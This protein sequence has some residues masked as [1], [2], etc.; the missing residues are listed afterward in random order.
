VERD[1]RGTTVWDEVERFVR[2]AMEP[3]FGRITELSGPRVSPDGRQVACTGK[4]WDRLEGMARSRICLVD[5]DGD[6]EIRQI[7]NGPNDDA[8]PVWSPDGTRLIFRSD[9]ASAGRYQLYVLETG[10]LGEARQLAEI[11][12]VVEHHAWSPDGSRILVVVAGANAE[13]ADALGSGTLTEQD[14]AASWLPDVESSDDPDEARRL[15]IVDPSSG[16]VRIVGRNDLNVWE[17]SWCGDAAI[18]A[19]AGPGTEEGAWYRSPLVVIDPDTGNDRELFASDVQLGW[20]CGA[21]DGGSVALIEAL[22]SDRYVVAGDLVLVDPIS[23]EA[24]RVDTNGVDV[25]WLAWR[26]PGRL[27]A[28]GLRGMDAVALEVDAM[29]GIAKEAWRSEDACGDWYPAGD[30]SG[31]DGFVAVVHGTDR[32]TGLARI[33]PRDERLLGSTTIASVARSASASVWCGRRTTVSRS[34]AS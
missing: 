16:D 5:I 23:H 18:V 8:D 24:T 19:V 9:R 14:E 30:P 31:E 2:D 22:C 27:L 11:P 17:A 7:T 3:G 28:M 29:A 34:R 33:T 26:G 21:P 15:W 32:P 20:A 12:G 4:R 6:G 13:Q 1:L 10:E 25:T